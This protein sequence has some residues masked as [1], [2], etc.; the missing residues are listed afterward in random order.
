MDDNTASASMM[1]SFLEH[2]WDILQQFI[3]LRAFPSYPIKHDRG[4]LNDD[5]D[6]PIWKPFVLS[7]FITSEGTETELMVSPV[8]SATL[9]VPTISTTDLN[10]HF[11]PAASIVTGYDCRHADASNIKRIRLG[12]SKTLQMWEVVMKHL[13]PKKIFSFT[14]NEML[15]TL[16]LRRTIAMSLELYKPVYDESRFPEDDEDNAF[17]FCV[18]YMA[19][20]Y[21]FNVWCQE[22]QKQMQTPDNARLWLSAATTPVVCVPR[23]PDD[24]DF[25][26]SLLC[27]VGP[28]Y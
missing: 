22:L 5:F 14:M 9:A 20:E 18:R 3:H 27:R 11:I 17:A 6:I 12:L 26:T 24:F 25:A 1:P 10:K 16:V 8:L 2:E 15:G 21:K 28:T 23:L 19:C 4:S 13:P 7:S